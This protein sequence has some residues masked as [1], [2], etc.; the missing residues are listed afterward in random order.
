MLETSRAPTCV[1]SNLNTN[2]WWHPASD[3][4]RCLTFMLEFISS[5]D[6]DCFCQLQLMQQWRIP[7][8]KSSLK[9]F[10]LFRSGVSVDGRRGSQGASASV[11]QWPGC[12]RRTHCPHRDAEW[13]GRLREWLQC[14]PSQQKQVE[15][16]RD[17]QLTDLVFEMKCQCFSLLQLLH[18]LSNRPAGPL[19]VLDKKTHAQRPTSPPRGCQLEVHR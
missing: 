9:L 13:E 19:L 10:F 7:L 18:H 8:L 11:F 4:S 1:A 15:C 2:P 12:S 16:L 3:V 6:K 17:K 14:G 5:I